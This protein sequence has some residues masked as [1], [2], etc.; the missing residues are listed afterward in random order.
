[1][2]KRPRFVTFI[3]WL[4]IIIG[5]VTFWVIPTLASDPTFLPTIAKQYTSTPLDLVLFRFYVTKLIIVILSVFMLRG[6]NWARLL[7]VI[8]GCA[9]LIFTA[10][11][12][13]ITVGVIL[14]CVITVYLLFRPK[15]NEFFSR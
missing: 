8:L 2:R 12:N 5:L 1:M 9:N 4:N 13:Q 11:P 3:C 7:Y 10:T 14:E 15:C 6:A